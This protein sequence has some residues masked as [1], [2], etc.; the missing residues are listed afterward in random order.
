M[1]HVCMGDGVVA[2]IEADVGG[3]PTLTATRSN[4]GSGVSSNGSRR[5]TSS[6]NT[7]S[8]RRSGSAG[9][10]RSAA[11]PRHHSHHR[12]STFAVCHARIHPIALA[13][14][15]ISLAAANVT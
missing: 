14:A 2:E 7:S 15:G 4:S 8:T 13:P 1:H 11:M 3:L 9:Q 5:S 6:T 10:R 12:F